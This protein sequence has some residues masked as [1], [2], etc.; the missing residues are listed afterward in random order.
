MGMIFE[1][2]LKPDLILEEEAKRVELGL[3]V[4]SPDKRHSKGQF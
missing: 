2:H 3:D 4:H 1:L